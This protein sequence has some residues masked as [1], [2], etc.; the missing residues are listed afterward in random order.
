MGALAS[1]GGPEDDIAIVY[2]LA[3][4]VLLHAFL[5]SRC[6]RR[7]HF[8][9]AFIFASIVAALLV[10]RH[11]EISGRRGYDRW[12]AN[13]SL[14]SLGWTLA[15]FGLGFAFYQRKRWR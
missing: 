15:W 2:L 10:A 3:P 1:W 14:E 12:H 7:L 9:S 5:V 8:I 6:G 4:F 13:R 11:I